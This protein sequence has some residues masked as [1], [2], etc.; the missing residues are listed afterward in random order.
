MSFCHFSES[1]NLRYPTVASDPLNRSSTIKI[2]D[3]YTHIYDGGRGL[4]LYTRVLLHIPY[5]YQNLFQKGKARLYQLGKWLRNRYRNFLP[6]KY[7]PKDIYVRS[8]NADRCL[9][10]AAAALAGLYRP[11]KSEVFDPELPWQPI[12]VHTMPPEDDEVLSMLKDCRRYRLALKKSMETHYFK[13]LRVHYEAFLKYISERSGAKMADMRDIAI[14]QAVLEMYSSYNASFLP[15]WCESLNNETLLYLAGVSQ[16]RF[17]LNLELKRLRTGPFWANFFAY[18]DNVI[19]GIDDT[20]KFVMLSA[21]DNTV[22]SLLN[23][24][25]AYDFVTPVFG[26]TLIWELKQADGKV[27]MEI[28]YK[29]NQAVPEKLRVR[30][31]D[32][33]CDYMLLKTVMAPVTVETSLWKEE[34]GN[35]I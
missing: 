18:F 9:M 20:P 22:V 8:T 3:D 14:L 33:D 28:F 15:S 11:E 35:D 19:N 2:V 5:R 13:E 32:V 1:A 25:G 10:S 34:C 21:H 31:C 29:R 4:S 16:E 27:W 26:A 7:S 24:M 23:S 30:G 12:P 6:Q 17:T